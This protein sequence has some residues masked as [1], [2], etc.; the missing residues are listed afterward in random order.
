MPSEQRAA[1]AHWFSPALARVRPDVPG[2]ASAAPLE[3]AAR[4]P[5]PSHRHAR[6]AGGGTGGV[7]WPTGGLNVPCAFLYTVPERAFSFLQEQRES[8]LRG[9]GSQ[10]LQVHGHAAHRA[11]R[12]PAG[13][14]V[15]RPHAPEPSGNELSINTYLISL[16]F[17]YYL[18]F[19]SVKL[20][21]PCNSRWRLDYCRNSSFCR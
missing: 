16:A 10:A 3:G 4:Q 11:E 9:Q 14:S 21:V 19:H 7:G 17:L 8:A 1:R 12:R 6:T 2:L 15:P 13:Q 20:V 18:F 5:R